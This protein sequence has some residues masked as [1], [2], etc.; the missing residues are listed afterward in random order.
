MATRSYSSK[1]TSR[2]VAGKSQQNER[3][4]KI[5]RPFSKGMVTDIPSWELDEQQSP[6]MQDII[7][8]GGIATYRGSPA[9]L[10][11]SAINGAVSTS[12]YAGSLPNISLN[13][14]PHLIGTCLA[15]NVGLYNFS[16]PGWMWVNPPNS[17][18]TTSIGLVRE[19]FN[20]EALICW[21][22]GTSPINRFSANASFSTGLNTLAAT[23]GTIASGNG[24]TTDYVTDIQGA[25][26]NFLSSCKAGSYI[27]IFNGQYGITTVRVLSVASDGSMSVDMPVN[28][29][30]SSY[31]S[32]YLGQIA[33]QTVVTDIG[34]AT[35]TNGSTAMSGLGTAWAGI[36]P[37]N[38][39]VLPNDSVFGTSASTAFFDFVNS[40][41]NS[42]TITLKLNYAGTTQTQGKYLI[43]RGAVGTEAREHRGVLFMTGVQ[44]A[45][46]RLYYTL[47]G[48]TPDGQIANT[49]SNGWNGLYS[50]STDIGHASLLQYIPVPSDRSE[51]SIVALLSSPSPLLILRNDSCYGLF[52]DVPNQDIRLIA[53]GAGC[54]DI[55]SAISNEWGQF[56]A[57]YEG[58]Y[59]YT[60]GKV[61]DITQGSRNREWRDLMSNY[62]QKADVITHFNMNSSVCCGYADH[63]LLV[64]VHNHVN[65][66][67]VS[68]TW[69]YD[70]QK[71]VWCGNF[72]GIDPQYYTTYWPKTQISQSTPQT[73]YYVP[74]DFQTNAINDNKTFYQDNGMMRDNTSQGTGNYPGTFIGDI[75]ESLDG[76]FDATDLTKIIE[77]KI[78]YEL[79][80]GDGSTV[81][82]VQS[83][84]DGSALGT[85]YT[86]PT[87]S[88]QTEARAYPV[89]DVTLSTTGS[90]GLLGRRHAMRITQTGTKPSHMKIHEVDILI[91]QR[92]DR[93]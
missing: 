4:N 63:Y 17:Y 68:Q 45:P 89:S 71:K 16:A 54:V 7:F 65:S 77:N 92:P 39:Q 75:P 57:G 13:V 59:W 15:N 14:P 48:A 93:S 67:N 6:N 37:L 49:L 5:Q 86:L 12:I 78:S 90:L 82:A 46:N 43:T 18:T 27:T 52:G 25:G 3:W 33:Q 56:W 36:A 76:D 41:T 72:S 22:D 60:G 87:V 31:F 61:V 91:R 88:T 64:S 2:K 58:I 80:G 51:G 44:W 19:I 62:L 50:T 42:S 28:F 29:T 26:S 74:G 47:F 69:V 79:S 73:M 38:G 32:N 30:S 53:D 85:D 23:A 20:G 24:I 34:V 81:V 9:P 55:R 66:F 11:S 40:V 8:S 21:Q 35:L 70:L 84:V 1:T 10:T 83:A